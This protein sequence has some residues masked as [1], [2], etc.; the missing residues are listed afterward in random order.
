MA[1]A[2]PDIYF[3][4]ETGYVRNGKKFNNYFGRIYEARYLSGIVAGM[5][6][7]SH[8][9]GYV[10]AQD[11]SNSEGLMVLMLLPLVFMK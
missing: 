9:I 6:T 5:N 7:R 11:Q 10:A 3:S 1:E 4:H 2:Y 8:K